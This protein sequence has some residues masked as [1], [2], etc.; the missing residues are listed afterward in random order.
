MK[1]RIRGIFIGLELLAV[2]ALI[3]V[4][5]SATAQIQYTS[6]GP[7]AFSNGG[8]T[9]SPYP[10]LIY[11]GTNGAA[12][13]PGVIQ[14]V[15]VTLNNFTCQQ[16]QE[17]SVLVEAP[18]G[19]ALEVMS[20]AGAA[21]NTSFVLGNLTIT[22]SAGNRMPQSAFGPGSYL[23]TAYNPQI[24]YPSPGPTAYQIAAP[25]GTSTL[26]D[27]FGR[28][29][30]NGTWQLF[31]V[32]QMSA[33]S[34]SVQSWSLNFT[35]TPPT[36]SVTGS[37]TGN[38]YQGEIGAQYSIVVTNAGLGP[39]GG[40]VP[41]MVVDTLPA[42]LTPTAASGPGWNCVISGQTVTC[43]ATNQTAADTSYPPITLTVNV[44]LNAPA[45]VSNA[46]TLTGSSD[47]IH[48]ATDPTTINPFPT[49]L[50][51]VNFN[52]N[53]LVST[54]GG[55]TFGPAMSGAAVLGE[56]VDQWNGIK[57]SSSGTGIP[58]IYANGSNSPVTM[59]FTSAGGYNVFSYSGT[60]PFVSSPYEPLMENY[61]YNGRLGTFAP[62]TITLSGLAANSAYNLVLY[63]AAD[64]AG[65]ARTTYFTVNSTTLSSTWDGASSTLIAGTDYVEFATAMSDGSGNLAINWTGNSTTEGDIN[66]FQIQFTN[67]PTVTVDGSEVY[68]RIDGFGASS[69]FRG[70]TWTTAQADMFF[71]T[72]NGIGLSLLRNQIQPGGFAAANEIGLMQMAQARGATIWSSPWSPQAS[73]KDTN[74]VN[75]G[76]FVSANNQA[77]ANQLA[78]YAATMKNTYGVNI[79][80]ISVQNEPDVAASYA[81]CL[82]TAQQIHDFVPYLYGAL[83]ASNVAAT[84]IMLPEDE[85]WETNYY[86]TAMS[87]PL[88]AADVGIV[89]NHNYDG[90]NFDTGATTPP[91]ALP[92]YGKS[93]WETEVST[94]DAFDGSISNA[95]YWA[96][97]IHQFLTGAQA[98]A[99]HYWGLISL[100]PDNE[101]LTDNAGNPAKRMYALGNF[102]LFVR[103][104]Y[105]RIG[106]NTSIPALI[107][108]YREPNSL[109]FAIVAINTNSFD[110]TNEI[111]ALA[112]LPPANF[113]TPWITSATFS[114]AA[115]SS[116]SVTNATFVYTL[117][118]MSVVTFVGPPPPKLG[119]NVAGP[120]S[121][122]IF[123]P[124][125][126]NFVLQTNRNLASTNWGNFSGSITNSNGFN[127]ITIAPPAGNLFFRLSQ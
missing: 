38:F 51:D 74:S 44:A 18:N 47:G 98:N 77:Y 11:V 111:F 100:N 95:I 17:V 69:A 99:W 46:V 126:W 121:V 20:S 91:A 36:L 118:A 82:W 62:Q 89:A 75:G 50:I 22:D 10:S 3:S 43:T 30:P 87:D 103:P 76:D 78:G 5:T 37:H 25:L 61:L 8:A 42:G 123:W 41:A 115:E 35:I 106:V 101:G 90:V 52:T 14:T 85:H 112:N 16:V 122:N 108:A 117:P 19:S 110:L 4:A 26:V 104:G 60:T 127:S 57:V 1:A 15:A 68:Q 7:I 48:I 125:T 83:A 23:P 71:S 86:L 88:V 12:S 70:S 73:F 45:N 93:L 102:S 53:S 114:L 124:G 107:S 40:S 59:T 66:G 32:N 49:T 84:K 109:G 113:V 81:S 120:G 13:L 9:A 92:A 79:Y 65:A 105:Y 63:N 64:T 55:V 31:L 96:G 80:A 67:P 21:T 33:A 24:T 34:G 97:R 116:V 29:N 39:T 94:G 54:G 28:L 6:G 58:L 119:I 72:N 2:L 27:A 56:A